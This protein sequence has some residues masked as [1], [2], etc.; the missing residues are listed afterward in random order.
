MSKR[1]VGYS[2]L[3]LKFSFPVE[4]GEDPEDPDYLSTL[5]AKVEPLLEYWYKN[6]D[7]VIDLFQRCDG[8]E[9]QYVT[10]YDEDGRAV[11]EWGQL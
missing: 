2:D 11:N 3:V 6:S 10:E 8:L 5:S 9:I 7:V 1:V 4:E